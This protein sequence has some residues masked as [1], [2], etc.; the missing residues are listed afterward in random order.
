MPVE[1]RFFRSDKWTDGLYKLLTGKFGVEGSQLRSVP[2]Y[3]EGCDVGVKVYVSVGNEWQLISGA[4]PV[5][6]VS[7]SNGDYKLQKSNTWSCPQCDISNGYVKIE[8]WV[9]LA[10][11]WSLVGSAKFRT[12]Q[13]SAGTQLDNALWSVSY[14]GSFSA[15]L[16]PTPRSQFTF[17][18]DGANDCKVAN[19]S[20]STVGGVVPRRK[21]LGMGR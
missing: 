3:H 14:V 20:Y 15:T 19:F 13:F 6:E 8:V 2:Q 18:F 1:T 21:L 10:G 12:E 17:W 7:Y 16:F 11:V 5:A 4:L 9:F